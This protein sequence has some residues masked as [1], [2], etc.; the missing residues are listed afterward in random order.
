[1]RF[2]RSLYSRVNINKFLIHFT[3]H[4]TNIYLLLCL[5][6]LPA[7]INIFM[8]FL[9]PRYCTLQHIIVGDK[10]HTENI[11]VRNEIVLRSKYLRNCSRFSVDKNFVVFAFTPFFIFARNRYIRLELSSLSPCFLMATAQRM[12]CMYAQ[13]MLLFTP[14]SLWSII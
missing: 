13:Q 8:C 3:M 14:C 5:L 6:L 4:V 11:T 9:S 2:L 7:L 12:C 10:N 1:M